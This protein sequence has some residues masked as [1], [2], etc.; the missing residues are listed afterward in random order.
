MSADGHSGLSSQ[1]LA[2]DGA[3]DSCA[4]IALLLDRVY[5]LG[6]DVAVES[7]LR[8]ARVARSSEYLRDPANWI[9]FAESMALWEAATNAT[10]QRSLARSIGATIARHLWTAPG[11]ESLRSAPSP[12][13]ALARL[14]A[15][16][17][18]FTRS[19]TVAVRE[20]RPGFVEVVHRPVDVS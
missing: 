5:E 1:T 19:A 9:S 4:L 18:Q 3:D 20:C 13:Q 14:A 16:L 10:H 7:V 6:G 2:D 17:S 11:G 15:T 8:R 12:E